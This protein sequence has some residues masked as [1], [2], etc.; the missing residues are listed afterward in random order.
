[1]KKS[2]NKKEAPSNRGFFFIIKNSLQELINLIKISLFDIKCKICE[3]DLVFKEEKHICNECYNSTKIGDLPVCRKCGKK[4]RKDLELCGEC[5]RNPPLYTRHLSFSTYEDKIREL[6]LKSK[7]REVEPLKNITVKYYL[8]TLKKIKSIKF[9][10]IIPIPMDKSRDR[11]YDHILEITKLLSNKL[12]INL[13]INNLIKKKQ[14]EPQ[15]GLSMAKRLKNLNGAFKLINPDKLR[16][17][18]ILLIDDVYTTGTTIKKCSEP[19]IKAGATV[20]AVTL[21]RS[22]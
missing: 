13:E 4:I 5:L 6:I 14:T 20:Y 1:M 8:E 10:F 12:N 3:N 11:E 15:A 16:N 17:K 22:V 2:S 21:A 18:T 9:D 7:Y 19:C